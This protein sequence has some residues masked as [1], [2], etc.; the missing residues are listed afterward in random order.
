[1]LEDELP[2]FFLFE[3]HVCAISIIVDS[4]QKLTLTVWKET[5]KFKRQIN[6]GIFGQG[7]HCKRVL[8]CLQ[9]LIEKP[10]KYGPERKWKGDSV[11]IQAREF[12]AKGKKR[13]DLKESLWG[14]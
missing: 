12:Q 4:K 6:G 11:T 7:S 3:K 13:N 10:V 9:V 1:M 8:H 5:V 14:S 2:C